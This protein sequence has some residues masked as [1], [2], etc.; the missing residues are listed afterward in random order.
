MNPQRISCKFFLHP[1]P[2]APVV[3]SPFI[4][5]FHR[6]IQEKTLDGLLLDVADYAH[7]PDGPGILLVGHDVDY[8][9]DLAEGRAGLLVVRKRY[10]ELP[11]AD[12]LR[13]ALASALGAIT[14][15]EADGS[16]DVRFATSAV[17]VQLLDRLATPNDDATYEAARSALAPVLSDLYG[18]K[19]EV[20]RAH[21]DDPRK[22]L[23]LTV[24]ANE[25]P[26]ADELAAR[27]GGAK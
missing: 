19:H 6:F 3:L 15:I 23:T 20:A 2:T 12:A 8:G 27:L 11:A 14:A 10:G 5:M 25:A 17:T 4:G 22:P 26:A 24:T 9:L 13:L 18:E 21:A 7:V 1:D 16:G